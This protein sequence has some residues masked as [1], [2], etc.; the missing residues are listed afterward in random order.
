MKKNYLLYLA[1]IMVCVCAMFTSCG[2]DEDEP[3]EIDENKPFDKGNTDKP[4]DKE[5][6]DGGN[7]DCMDSASWK[8]SYTGNTYTLLNSRGM[9][10]EIGTT[11]NQNVTIREQEGGRLEFVYHNWT[12]HQGMN[13]G[14]FTIVPLDFV[15]TPN[16]VSISGECSDSLYKAGKPYFAELSVEGTIAN[17]DKKAALDIKVNLY[18]SPAMTL[19]FALTYNGVAQ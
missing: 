15:E 10:I 12:D 14:D 9:D 2:D 4:F 6:T 13:Y 1:S 16:G 19:K 3:F 17:A 18:V 5:N 8:C 7:K 11:E